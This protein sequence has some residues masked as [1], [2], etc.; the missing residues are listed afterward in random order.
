M[1]N[2]DFYFESTGYLSS[3]QLQYPNRTIDIVAA[4]KRY[5]F[6]PQDDIT[7]LEAVWIA[8]FFAWRAYAPEHP[9]WQLIKRHFT[10]IK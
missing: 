9:Q 6:T 3:A 4:S 1:S 5:D 7:P 8:H 2:E 10:E